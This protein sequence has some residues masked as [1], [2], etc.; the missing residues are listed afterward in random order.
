MKFLMICI[1]FLCSIVT[2][3]VNAGEYYRFAFLGFNSRV[4]NSNLSDDLVK[5]FPAIQ[6]MMMLELGECEKIELIDTTGILQQFNANELVLPL[7]ESKVPCYAKAFASVDVDYYVY[8]YITNMSIKD[9]VQAIS[10]NVDVGGEAKTVEVDLSVNIMDAKTMKKVF[11]ATGKG[12]ESTAKTKFAYG[13]HTVKFGGDF[14]PEENVFKAISK[15]T[16][17]IGMKII[18]SI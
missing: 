7:D 8:G 10:Y 13:A 9:S 16:R 3:T 11:V 1:A 12:Q 6:E 17:Q 15:A 18:K 5:N 4:E 14:I 2:N